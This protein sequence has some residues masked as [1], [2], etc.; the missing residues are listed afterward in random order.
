MGQQPIEDKLTLKKVLFRMALGTAFVWLAAMSIV[1]LKSWSIYRNA[2]GYEKNTFV[3]SSL[4][5][6]AG[7]GKSSRTS[8]RVGRSGY[9]KRPP[10]HTASGARWYARG[11]VGRASER[12]SLDG[13]LPRRPKSEQDLES[14][15][16]IGT[17]L[18]VWYNPAQPQ[19][20]RVL[21]Y[22]KDCF[23]HAHIR[24]V[25]VTAAGV[26]PFVALCVTAVILKVRSRRR[27]PRRV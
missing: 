25:L 12:F 5:Y 2:D 3:V 16:S 20:L 13:V 6:R 24:A 19:D 1:S 7:S 21:Q 14:M 9:R 26:A 15:V 22:D 10:R 23:S 8:V 18:K 11:T 4:H 27:E 17:Q